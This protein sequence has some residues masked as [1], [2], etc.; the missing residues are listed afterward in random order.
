MGT[1]IYASGHGW[2]SEA[3]GNYQLSPTSLGFG[4][5]QRLANINDAFT[6]PDIGAHQSGTA[7]MVFGVGGSASQWVSGAS[8]GGGSTS[9][10]S[11][12]STTTTSTSTPTLAGPGLTP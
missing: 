2:Q 9:V 1:P 10:G 5:A 8:L 3:G 6:A 4:K 11:G 12:G 7:S